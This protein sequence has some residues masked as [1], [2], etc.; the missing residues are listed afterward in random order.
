ME[1][2]P[3]RGDPQMRE[4]LI[5]FILSAKDDVGWDRSL[6]LSYCYKN[7]M[8]F[9]CGY[10][11]TIMSLIKKHCKGIEPSSFDLHD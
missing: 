5:K 9:G 3:L 8:L 2:I 4:S 1:E 10:H 11:E 6:S 7:V